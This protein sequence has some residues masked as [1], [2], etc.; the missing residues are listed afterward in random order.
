[1][2]KVEVR[3]QN[4]NPSNRPY[5]CVLTSAFLFLHSYFCIL[6]SDLCIRLSLLHSLGAVEQQKAAV[7][8]DAIA[9]FQMPLTKMCPRPLAPGTHNI[10]IQSCTDQ[11]ACNR[12]HSPCPLL[13]HF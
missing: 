11:R 3:M 7:A 9:H 4:E 5:F 13:Y 1:M 8:S 12:N 2:Q 6:T 10:V